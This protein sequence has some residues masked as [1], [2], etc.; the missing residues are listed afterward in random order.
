MAKKIL[1]IGGAVAVVLGILLIAF[2][3]IRGPEPALEC[4]SDSPQ[5]STSGGGITVESGAPTSG[6]EITDKGC[7]ASIESYQKWASWK[8]F[9]PAMVAM[10][11]SGAALI[12]LGI[13]SAVVG[14]ILALTRKNKPVE[15]QTTPA[16][17]FNEPPTTPMA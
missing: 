2:S 3:D 17:D 13:I 7:P 5:S 4:A 8:K 9:P 6:F 10:R 16:Q 1:M 14:L 12:G 11:V 15:Q